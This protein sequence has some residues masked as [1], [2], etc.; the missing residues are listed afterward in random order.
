[1]AEN[2]AFTRKASGL[3]RG[4]NVYDAFGFGLFTIMPIYVIWWMILAGYG[5]FVGANLYITIAITFVFLAIPSTIT[6]GVLGATMPRSGGDYLYNTRIINPA[7]G[8]AASMGTILAYA[9]WCVYMATYITL[10]GL[11]MMGQ[12]MGWTG[13]TNFAESKWG[14]FGCAVAMYAI[15][16]AVIFFGWRVYNVIQRPLLAVTTALIGIC[17]VTLLFTSRTEFINLWNSAA[18]TYQSLNYNDFIA[19]TEAASGGSWSGMWN[20]SNTIAATTA[21]FLLVMYGYTQCYMGGEI[22]EPNMA[23]PLA[24]L[25]AGGVTIVL[26]LLAVLG[27]NHIADMKFLYAAGYN[28]MNPVEGYTFPWDTTLNGLVFMGSGMNRAIGVIFALMWILTTISMF[29]VIITFLQRTLFAWGMD[30]MGPKWFT[31]VSPRWGVP[32]KTYALVAGVLAALTSVYV[33]WLSSQFTGLMASEISLISVFLV[34]GISATI[35]PFRKRVRNIW[36]SSPYANW[37]FLGIPVVTIGGAVYSAFVVMLLYYSIIDSR[38][39]DISAKNTIVL[40]AAWVIGICW[41]LF[42]RARAKRMDVS[43]GMVWGELPPD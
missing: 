36:R 31:D 19:A 4:L 41:Y 13:L 6:W 35:L 15:T 11:Q 5:I 23:M 12:V 7:I 22:K 38:T 18:A 8:M 29:A 28:A 3:V 10:P 42:W 30:R 1:M 39:R 40:I 37:K 25:L 26:G 34:S 17:F 2:L 21:S 27:L 33:V 16:L 14:Q 32:V 20:W 9:Y 43:M 24:N